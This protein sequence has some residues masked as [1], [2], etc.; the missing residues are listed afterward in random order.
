[1]PDFESLF[2]RVPYE[3]DIVF[4]R[5]RRRVRIDEAI[6]IPIMAL[7][8]GDTKPDLLVK[9]PH[10]DDSIWLNYVDVEGRLF[11]PFLERGKRHLW[12]PERCRG[13]PPGMDFGSSW[14]SNC[15]RTTMLGS[16][17]RPSYV[18]VPAA[19][20]RQARRRAPDALGEARRWPK[21]ANAI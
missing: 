14:G 17:F 13:D 5:K 21:I 9:T 8:G 2:V 16:P 4:G 18:D 7:V 6:E 11:R 19:H 1:M 20:R 12:T 15:A 10:A 3:A